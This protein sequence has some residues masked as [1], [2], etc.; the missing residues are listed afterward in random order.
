MALRPRI[1]N[2]Y[3]SKDGHSII[4]RVSFVELPYLLER[5]DRLI[6]EKGLYPYSIAI[7]SETVL[8]G[9]NYRKGIASIEISS[10]E[11][12]YEKFC[13][14]MDEQISQD[15]FDEWQDSVIQETMAKI[16][17]FLQEEVEVRGSYCG[18]IDTYE[19]LVPKKYY[20]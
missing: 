1:E 8:W 5:L 20:S 11:W 13:E 16:W 6:E 4:V 15:E 14:E 17:G 9:C 10:D 12:A 3:M 18:E 7:V 2:A 19:P